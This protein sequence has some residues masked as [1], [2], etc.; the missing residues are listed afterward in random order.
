VLSHFAA[1]P[2][3]ASARTHGYPGCIRCQRIAPPTVRTSPSAHARRRQISERRERA[4]SATN[5]MHRYRDPSGTSEFSSGST[6]EVGKAR[7]SRPVRATWGTCGT[8]GARRPSP[9]AVTNTAAACHLGHLRA[10]IPRREAVARLTL[11]FGYR[12]GCGLETQQQLLLV[13]FNN[14]LYSFNGTTVNRVVDASRRRG[15]GTEGYAAGKVGIPRRESLGTLV[16][17]ERYQVG[18]KRYRSGEVGVLRR[19]SPHGAR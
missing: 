10:P 5:L 8:V 19:G 17:S 7:Y 12:V 16:G 4:A 15:A 11:T 9:D 13:G 14:P 6:A 3:H 1:V 2:Q 18:K